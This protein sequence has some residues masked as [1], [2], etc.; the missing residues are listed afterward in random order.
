MDR[1]AE[2]EL[3][4]RA[5]ALI[6]NLTRAVGA[7]QNFTPMEMLGILCTLAVRWAKDHDIHPREYARIS[8]ELLDF[9]AE[10]E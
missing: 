7:Q 3:R 10:E 6:A 4:Q 8:N 1:K 5:E 9:M 2:K